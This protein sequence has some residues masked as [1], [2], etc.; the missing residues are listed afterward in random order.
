MTQLLTPA[1]V[2]KM[3]DERIAILIDVKEADEFAREHIPGTRIIPLS[4]MVDAIGGE[5]H[6]H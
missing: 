5:H 4:K 1:T 2:K 3:L 6:D